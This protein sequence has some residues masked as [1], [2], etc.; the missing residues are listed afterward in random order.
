MVERGYRRRIPAERTPIGNLFLSTMAQIYPE[1]WGAN[2][3]IGRGRETARN[4]AREMLGGSGR[5]GSGG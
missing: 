4:L 2:L 5:S 3:A 1:D